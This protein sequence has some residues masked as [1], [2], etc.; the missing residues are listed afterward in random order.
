[1][2]AVVLRE[3]GGPEV[4][5]VE[6]VPDPVPQAGEVLVKL[7][8]AALNKRDA[9]IRQGMYAGLRYPIILGSDGFGEVVAVGEGVDESV[10]GWRVVIDPSLDWG[11]DAR[12]QGPAFRILGLPDDGTYAEY[13]RVPLTNIHLAPSSLTAEEAAAIPLAGLTAY[14]AV[15]TRGQAQ[16]DEHVVVTGAGGGV[17]TFAIQMARYAGARVHVTSGSDAKLARAREFGAEVGVN[18]RTEGWVQTLRELTDGG[19]HLIIDGAGGAQFDQL[20][21][22][23]RPGGRIV[24]YGSTLGDAPS[25]ALR[26]IFWKQVT[27]LGT[28]MGTDHEF[29]DMLKWIENGAVLPIVDVAYPLDAIAQAHQRMDDAEQ[30]GKIVLAI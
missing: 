28:T 17:A 2:R 22:L 26:R 7:Q 29:A 9:W 21:D 8:A 24:C 1:M 15:V 16:V 25:L 11:R 13:V 20:L 27:I 5:R 10:E 30:F 23:V 14:R 4:L 3:Q 18:Y 12:V 6:Q 19:P